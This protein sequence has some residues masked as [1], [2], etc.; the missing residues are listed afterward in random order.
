M[1][2]E[3]YK[4][5]KENRKISDRPIVGRWAR[6]KCDWILYC[7]KICWYF[8][9]R[10]VKSFIDILVRLHDANREFTQQQIHDEVL[11]MI[12][13][14]SI[15]RLG[16]L[17]WFLQNII[18]ES[19]FHTGKRIDSYSQLVYSSNVGNIPRFAG[20]ASLLSPLSIASDL[21][22]ILYLPGKSLPRNREGIRRRIIGKRLTDGRFEQNQVP[23]TVH[24]RDATKIYFS[25]YYVS[26]H[27]RG[28]YVNQYVYSVLHVTS[29]KQH[30][31]QFSDSNPAMYAH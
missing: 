1:K 17:K 19:P 14:V 9:D 31:R 29:V 23:G 24:Q 11:V 16:I 3:E 8:T 20:T 15:L 5:Q 6:I 13:A 12:A 2:L 7:R 22:G 18:I 27:Y 21:T 25:T 10:P 26:G 30:E 4:K 28:D